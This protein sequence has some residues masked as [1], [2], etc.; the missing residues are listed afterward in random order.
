MAVS[1]FYTPSGPALKVHLSGSVVHSPSGVPL[2]VVTFI[3]NLPAGT[4]TH[5]LRWTGPYPESAAEDLDIVLDAGTVVCD[6]PSGRY[7]TDKGPHSSQQWIYKNLE[8][9]IGRA[10]ERYMH[11]LQRDG[12]DAT[13]YY[14]TGEH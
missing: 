1:P 8:S 7:R 9:A 13:G 4:V 6:L 12:I 5:R 11:T 14:E 3:P 10:L 2:A